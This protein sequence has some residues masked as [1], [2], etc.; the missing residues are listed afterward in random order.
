MMDEIDAIQEGAAI[1]NAGH[2]VVPGELFHRLIE[3]ARG[4]TKNPGLPQGVLVAGDGSMN[5][6]FAP[7]INPP[8]RL[9]ALR[10]GIPW[11]GVW[12]LCGTERK[13]DGPTEARYRMAVKIACHDGEIDF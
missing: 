8:E 2:V 10:S 12:V 7:G 11:G 4:E 13:N 9:D 3:I 1:A 6:V 5:V